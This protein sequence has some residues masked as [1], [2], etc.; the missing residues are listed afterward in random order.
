M[1]V[2]LAEMVHLKLGKVDDQQAT[3]RPDEARRLTYSSLRVG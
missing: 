3:A 1:A 2:E